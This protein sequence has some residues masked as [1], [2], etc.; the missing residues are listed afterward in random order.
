MYEYEVQ[1]A[2][3]AEL[4]RRAEQERLVREAVRARRAA[5]HDAATRTAE[6]E[7]HTG[8]SRRRWST[9]AA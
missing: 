9:R 4:I 2:R 5:R 3:T 8:R 1:Q 6:A 7:G